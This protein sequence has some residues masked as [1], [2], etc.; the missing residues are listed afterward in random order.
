MGYTVSVSSAVNRHSG[1]VYCIIL[2]ALLDGWLLQVSKDF[3]V[4]QYQLYIQ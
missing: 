2:S 4:Q 1:M 3:T